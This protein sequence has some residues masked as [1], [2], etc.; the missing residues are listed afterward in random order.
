MLDNIDKD[1]TYTVQ[2][3][4]KIKEELEVAIMAVLAV[5]RGF[6]PTAAKRV[7]FLTFLF[8]HVFN[9]LCI[10]CTEKDFIF[11]FILTD[12]LQNLYEIFSL[13]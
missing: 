1:S 11:R 12:I 2:R 10:L 6:Y 13:V 3:A 7:V 9:S 4:E 5:G 8:F